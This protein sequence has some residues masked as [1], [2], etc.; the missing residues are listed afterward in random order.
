M[1]RLVAGATAGHEPDLSLNRRVGPDDERRVV[2]YAQQIRVRGF[3][4]AQRLL[5]DIAGRVDELLHAALR[6][7]R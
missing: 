6:G 3:H 1:H 4:P 7:I 5:H 2:T